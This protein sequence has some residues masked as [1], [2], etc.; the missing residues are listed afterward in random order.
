MLKILAIYDELVG[1]LGE[2]G[3][4]YNNAFNKIVFSDDNSFELADEAIDNIKKVLSS[5]TDISMVR[6]LKNV[7]PKEK[8]TK[9]YSKIRTGAPIK[10]TDYIK[11]AKAD[12]EVGQL[13]EMLAL[14][15]EKERLIK[16]GYPDLAAKVRRVS[17]VS[18]AYGYDIESY[19]LIG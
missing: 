12:M 17:I 6:T 4:D 15:Y 18:D 13:G 8:R 14:E 7:E 19:E 16:Q 2:D 1:V 3:Y 5:P 10:K 9:K 11:K